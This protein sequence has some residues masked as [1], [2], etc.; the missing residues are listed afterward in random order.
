MRTG[1]N[2]LLA[3]TISLGYPNTF[4]FLASE[5]FKIEKISFKTTINSNKNLF[6]FKLFQQV[7]TLNL[8]VNG[9]IFTEKT[10]KL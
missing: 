5:S 1:I 4:S 2:L 3:R 7:R 6:V 9:S 10:I 8:A